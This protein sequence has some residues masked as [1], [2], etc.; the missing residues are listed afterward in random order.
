MVNIMQTIAD[1]VKRVIPTNGA[2]KPAER[3]PAYSPP[4]RATLHQ[5]DDKVHPM[6]AIAIQSARKW[7]VRRRDTPNA[8]LVLVASQSYLD[9]AKTIP[10]TD[11]TGFG[12]GK[13]HIARAILWSICLWDG[14]VPVAPVGK[15]HTAANLLELVSEGGE[16]EIAAL[17]GT[18]PILVIDDVGSEGELPFVSASRQGNEK[19]ARYFRVID[20]CYRKGIAVIVTSNLSFPALAGHMGGRCWSRLME[21]AP[22]GYMLDLTGVPDYRRKTSGR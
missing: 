7:Q 12:C 10:D 14:D 2:T 18:A 15:F 3:K 5:L 13:T 1:L 17:L 6:I 22:T 11:R 19:Q 20:Y 8:S 16:H 21:M 4:E 9:D